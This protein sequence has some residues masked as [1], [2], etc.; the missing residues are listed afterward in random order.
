MVISAVS[1]IL[2]Y[3]PSLLQREK[4]EFF[5][6]KANNLKGVCGVKRI[7]PLKGDWLCKLGFEKTEQIYIGGGTLLDCPKVTSVL[8]ILN[9][10]EASPQETS[11]PKIV[12]IDDKKSIEYCLE[13]HL[14]YFRWGRSGMDRPKTGMSRAV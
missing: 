2:L 6:F 14:D 13:S 1:D 12:K 9:F 7:D 10:D 11:T 4:A 8:D 3:C 5:S